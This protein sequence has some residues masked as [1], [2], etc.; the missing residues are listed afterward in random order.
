MPDLKLTYRQAC[1]LWSLSDE[2]CEIALERLIHSG[3]LARTADGSYVRG[4]QL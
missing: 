3:F 2:R 4:G 1:R